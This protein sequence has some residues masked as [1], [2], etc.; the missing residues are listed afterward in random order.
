MYIQERRKNNMNLRFFEGKNV[1]L[2]DTDGEIF[3]GYVTDYIFAKDNV[4]KE[5]ESIV[6][7]YPIRKSDGY[8]YQNLV[9]FTA[10]E[11]KSIEVML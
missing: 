9:E 3:E 5:A 11:I 6:L 10:S 2:T 4:P 1:R 7:D 8:K